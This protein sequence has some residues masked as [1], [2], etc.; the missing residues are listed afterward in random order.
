MGSRRAKSA[1]RNLATAGGARRSV[2]KAGG[3]RGHFGLCCCGW[4]IV[5]SAPEGK[6]FYGVANRRDGCTMVRLLRPKRKFRLSSITGIRGWATRPVTGLLVG[7]VVRIAAEKGSQIGAIKVG[8]EFGGE[9][10]LRNIFVGEVPVKIDDDRT[11]FYRSNGL[12]WVTWVAGHA[13][14]LHGL[15]WQN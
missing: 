5:G 2:A 14:Q 3:I 12:S 10:S 4:Q 13:T 11:I 6:S 15:V 8:A 9:R 1:A 7:I